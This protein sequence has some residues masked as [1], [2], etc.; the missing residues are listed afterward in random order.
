MGDATIR[1][2]RSLALD[3]TRERDLRVVRRSRLSASR[4]LT[5]ALTIGMTTSAYAGTLDDIRAKGSI[6]LGYR[7][8]SAPFSSVDASGQP[9]GYSIDLCLRIVAAVKQAIGLEQLSVVYVP[10]TAENRIEKLEAGAIDIE[11]GSTTRTLSRQQR[12]DFTLLTFITG[13]ELLVRVGS[14]IDG[15][16]DLEGRK[17]AVLPGTTTEA[18]IR[19]K[20]REQ[21]INATVVE[22]RDHDDGFAA[23]SDGRADAYASDE[24]ILIG[25]ARNSKD[26]GNLRL[27]GTIYSYEPYALMLRKNDAE[28]RLVAD[29]ALAETYRSGRIGGVYERWFGKWAAR[30]NPTLLALYLIQSLPD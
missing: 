9:A 22:V 28:F 3:P 21:L 23:L 15:L 27:S 17:V 5:L 20:L 1:I 29:R 13:A 4:L 16:V 10:V 12:V 6:A 19:A 26:A 30:P 18:T 7:T 2:E 24:I 14:K 11:C 8:A 25:L